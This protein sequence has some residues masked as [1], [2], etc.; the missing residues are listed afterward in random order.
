MF[1]AQTKPHRF[2][3]L[4]TLCR[5]SIVALALIHSW[6][7]AIESIKPD[8]TNSMRS[9]DVLATIASAVITAGA[10]NAYSLYNTHIGSV[11]AHLSPSTVR[12]EI[13]WLCERFPIFLITDTV[14]GVRHS[15]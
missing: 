4:V 10:I 2:A 6:Q 8:K 1:N 7:E 9:L 15:N 14:N 3:S 12:N 11:G 13:R 5:L